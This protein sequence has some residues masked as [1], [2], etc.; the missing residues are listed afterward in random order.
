[1]VAMALLWASH[2]VALMRCCVGKMLQDVEGL[3]FLAEAIDMRK[4]VY[5]YSS[6]P[7]TFR[8][9]DKVHHVKFTW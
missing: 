7:R 3:V 2:D 5:L 1:M 4:L 6:R 8:S 9:R